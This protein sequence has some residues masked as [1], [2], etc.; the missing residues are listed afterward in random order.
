MD[1]VSIDVGRLVRKTGAS[2]YSSLVTRPTG[3]AVRLA[4]ETVLAEEVGPVSL[5][6]IEPLLRNKPELSDIKSHHERFDGRGYPDGL[7]GKTIPLEARIMAVAD[8]FDAMTTNRPSR[9]S[10]SREMA[11][12]EFVDLDDKETETKEEEEP[13]PTQTRSRRK[14]QRPRALRDYQP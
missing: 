6:I 12:E 5:S 11:I 7:F 13:E 9:E 10:L 8:S 3:Q 1:P 4:I 2:L 14:R